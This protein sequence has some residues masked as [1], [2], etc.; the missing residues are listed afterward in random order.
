MDCRRWKNLHASIQLLA[1]E[2][3]LYGSAREHDG[4]YLAVSF[5]QSGHNK[6][7]SFS[8][9]RE[10]PALKGNTD[11]LLPIFD[12]KRSKQLGFQYIFIHQ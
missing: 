10:I 4:D 8:R 5:K 1:S 6:L 11:R 7:A 3:A 12:F 9:M 2:E